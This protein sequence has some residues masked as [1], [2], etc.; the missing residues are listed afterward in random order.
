MP[1]RSRLVGWMC[2]DCCEEESQ[3]EQE[4]VIDTEAPRSLRGRT[5]LKRPEKYR[6]YE[7]SEIDVVISKERPSRAVPIQKPSPPLPVPTPV[8]VPCI[9]LK[10]GQDVSSNN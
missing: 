3:D 10:T 5:Q 8:L 1:R 9:P 6:S 4:A 7:E 2:S